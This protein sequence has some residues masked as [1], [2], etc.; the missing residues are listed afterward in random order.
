MGKNFHFLWMNTW[1]LDNFG[2]V[3]EMAEQSTKMFHFR[4]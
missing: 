1:K 4:K 2:I 3:F